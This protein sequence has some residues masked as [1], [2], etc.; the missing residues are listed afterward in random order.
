[1]KKDFEKRAK[2]D[3]RN[4]LKNKKLTAFEFGG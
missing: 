3:K 2:E 4:Q 1:L